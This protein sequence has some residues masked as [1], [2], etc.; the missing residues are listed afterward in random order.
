MIDNMP[1]KAKAPYWAETMLELERARDEA[2]RERDEARAREKSMYEDAKYNHEKFRAE[3]AKAQALE[4]R[5]R[6]LRRYHGGDGTVTREQVFE[7][8]DTPT[9]STKGEK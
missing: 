7:A 1:P 9:E 5:L 8:L 6:L 4:G 2:I 3:R